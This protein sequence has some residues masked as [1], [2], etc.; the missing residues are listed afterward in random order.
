MVNPVAD[1]LEIRHLVASYAD[2]VNRRDQALWAS[3][4]AED[5]HWSLPGAGRFSGKEAVVGFW[6]AAM[7]RLDFVA[8]LGYQGTL[9]INGDEASGRWYFYEH[10]RPAGSAEG[11]F[12][13][14]TY[15]DKY[16][17]QNGKWLFMRRDYHIMY[18]DEGKGNM[19]GTVI[20]IPA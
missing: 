10:I 2:A 12:T 19:R 6:Q 14:G 11:M 7:G 20:P 9:E 8:Q 16:I 13:I 15:K 18:N 4:W 1:E 5:C 17:K 3:T